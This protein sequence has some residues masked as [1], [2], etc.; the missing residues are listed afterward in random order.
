MTA[1]GRNGWEG[2]DDFRKPLRSPG[3]SLVGWSLAGQRQDLVGRSLAGR[4][5]AGWNPGLAS[6][7]LEGQGWSLA[8]R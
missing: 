7:S 6:W 5:L 1:E 8:L 3:W 2:K 4:S